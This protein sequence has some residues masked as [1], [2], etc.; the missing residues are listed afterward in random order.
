LTAP[1]ISRPADA[2]SGGSYNGSTHS[3]SVSFGVVQMVITPAG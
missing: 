2:E 1:P 3:V